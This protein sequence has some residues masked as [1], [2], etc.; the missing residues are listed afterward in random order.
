MSEVIE[1]EAP[2]VQLPIVAQCPEKIDLVTHSVPYSDT[3]QIDARNDLEAVADW[4]NEYRRN[5]N[6]YT[7]YRRESMRFLVWCVY[8]AGKA[9]G[10][11]KKHD[12]ENYFLFLQNPPSSWTTQGDDGEDS[13]SWQPFVGQLSRSAFLTAV[14]IINSMM[15][16]LVQADYLKSNPIK[17]IRKYSKLSIDFEEQKYKVWERM[18]ENDEWLAVQRA[19]KEMP[20]KTENE[21][22]NKMRTQF[23]FAVLY[24]LGLRI[25]EVASHT[26]SNFRRKN[27][28]LWFFVQGKGEKLGHIPVNDQ[29]LTHIKVYRTYLGK[30]PD[31]GT[32]EHEHLIISKKTKKPLKI[33]QLYKLVKAIGNKAASYFSDD[34]EKQKKLQAL[35]PHWLRHLTA[36]HQDKLG[37]PTSIIKGNLRH[38]SIQTTQIYIHGEDEQRFNEMQ[39]LQMS[40]EP[41]IVEKKSVLVGYEFKLILTRGPIDKSMG[42]SMLLDGIENQIFKDLDWVRVGDDSD[43]LI[44]SIKKQGVLCTRVELIYQVRSQ[45]VID[46]PEVWVEALKRQ[47]QIWMFAVDIQ[48]TGI[49]SD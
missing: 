36:S 44:H 13:D 45:E 24:L 10:S 2:Q 7:S 48:S 28:Q 33:T 8:V 18:L 9:M 39:K 34:Y 38:Q 11:L 23:L 21:V 14:R 43:T 29:L 20:E 16:Y 46:S 25:H 26:W 4:L 41:L 30:S 1:Y 37:M 32:G 35:S 40:H 19:L 27:G 49:K 17:L 31:P 47:A 5:Q 42:I 22:D 6:T 15:N 12:F 3:C